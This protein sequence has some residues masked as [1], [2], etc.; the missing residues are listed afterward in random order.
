MEQIHPASF[1]GMKQRKKPSHLWDV[2]GCWPQLPGL[3]SSWPGHHPAL[4][5]PGSSQLEAPVA[6]TECWS[7]W[8]T[9]RATLPQTHGDGEGGTPPRLPAPRS[10]WARSDLEGVQHI[11]FSLYSHQKGADGA[12]VAHAPQMTLLVGGDLQKG[13]H[14]SDPWSELHHSHTRFRCRN[15]DRR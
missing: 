4:T 9:A 2:C 6:A 3:L 1:L 14:R 8:R 13:I 11:P 12:G 10:S 7:G 15:T 5:L